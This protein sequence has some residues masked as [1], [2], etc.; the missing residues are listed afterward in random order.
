MSMKV[1]VQFGL[2]FTQLISVVNKQF[3]YRQTINQIINETNTIRITYTFC[4]F[5]ERKE[6][7]DEV[8]RL[9]AIGESINYRLIKKHGETNQYSKPQP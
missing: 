4:L 9:A 1:V 5:A 3:N 7:S 8:K 2:I 6:S